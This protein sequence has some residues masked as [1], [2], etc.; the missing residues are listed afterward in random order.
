MY[1]RNGDRVATLNGAASMI[2][3]AEP[4]TWRIL[5]VYGGVA[6]WGVPVVVPELASGD[7]E[8]ALVLDAEG[9]TILEITVYRTVISSDAPNV[10][11]GASYMIPEPKPNWAG[12]QIGD[13][14]MA[15]QK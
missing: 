15:F 1:I 11:S 7:P 9:R 13:L 14:T 12:I 10:D 6:Q 4:G 5:N 8:S 3:V 2:G